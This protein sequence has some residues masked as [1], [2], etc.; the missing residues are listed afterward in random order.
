[1][2]AK[3][4]PARITSG[5]AMQLLGIK[6]KATWRKV[7]DANPHLAH[8]LPGEVRAKYLTAAVLAL[9]PASGVRTL[10]EDKRTP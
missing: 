2:S 4:L 7:V 3:P 6:A 8:K 1:M 5:E 9:L 10:G